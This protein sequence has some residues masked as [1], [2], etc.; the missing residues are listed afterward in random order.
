[1]VF[2]P[3]PRLPRRFV[4][5]LVVPVDVEFGFDFDFDFEAVAFEGGLGRLRVVQFDF[6]LDLYLDVHVRRVGHVRR[7][8]VDPK[9]VTRVGDDAPSLLT[10]GPTFE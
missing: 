8:G 1:M 5:A 9:Q 2:V 4:L 3:L 10:S 6:H 7:C